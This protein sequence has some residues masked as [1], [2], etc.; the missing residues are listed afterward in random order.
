MPSRNIVRRDAS[1][2]YYHVYL[3]GINKAPVFAQDADKEYFLYLLSRHLSLKPVVT[4]KGYRYAHL[5]GKLELLTY[6]LMDN[7]FH[8]LVFQVEK[9][10]LSKLMQGVLTAYTAYYN[11]TYNH[12]GPIF[13][14][15]YKASIILGDTYL[16]HISRYILLNP[17]SWKRYRFSS[18]IYMRSSA[19]PEWLQTERV[20]NLHANREA[21]LQFIYDYEDNKQVLSKIKHQLANV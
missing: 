12:R 16:L 1:E 7:H 20:L 9:S 21:Y 17:R 6:C 2:S 10:A 8:M 18:I 11:R 13:E 19:E 15:S 4:K 14:S 5:R 3:R